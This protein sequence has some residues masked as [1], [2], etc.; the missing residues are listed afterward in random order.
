MW[1]GRVDRIGILG[2]VCVVSMDELV[3]VSCTSFSLNHVSLS[4]TYVCVCVCASI[5][6]CPA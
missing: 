5:C 2:G 1:E 6:M 4:H 3:C